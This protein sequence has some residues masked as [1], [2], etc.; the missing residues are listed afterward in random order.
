MKIIAIVVVPDKGIVPIRIDG[1]KGI[2]QIDDLNLIHLIVENNKFR[3]DKE[4]GLQ[5]TCA[6]HLDG[7]LK[8]VV[9]TYLSEEFSEQLI[10]KENS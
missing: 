10:E 3:I 1:N 9:D 8:N 7:C 2:N 4:T 5:I 6:I